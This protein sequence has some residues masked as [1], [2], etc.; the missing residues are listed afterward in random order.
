MTWIHFALLTIA[1]YGIF[2]LF[3]KLTSGKMH[4]SFAGFIINSTA[5]LLLL[6]YMFIARAQGAKI[7]EVKSGG[8]MYAV[9]GG[10]VIGLTSIC[11]LKM[12]EANPNYAVA[13]PFVR[14]GIVVI[15]SLIG[16][17]ILKDQVNA[18]KYL[19]GFA[20]AMIGFYLLLSAGK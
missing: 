3:V 12:F 6:I 20:L 10:I 4:S 18:A 5:A 8:Y 7:F 14:I 11:F 17:F 15:A 13:V 2:D 9:I 1:G 16:I 19:L